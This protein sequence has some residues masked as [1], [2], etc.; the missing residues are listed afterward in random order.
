MAFETLPDIPRTFPTLSPDFLD[1]K[2][3]LN[4]VCKKGQGKF[5]GKNLEKNLGKGL[6][7]ILVK[8]CKTKS[9]KKSRKKSRKKFRESL[10]KSQSLKCRSLGR[11]SFARLFSDFC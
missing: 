3:I 2:K 1:D 11:L 10:E 7:K 4:L 5:L 9:G 8:D 6:G